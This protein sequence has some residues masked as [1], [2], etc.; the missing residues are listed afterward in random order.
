VT[1]LT[2]DSQG[3]EIAYYVTLSTPE[4]DELPPDQGNA[5]APGES[6]VVMW[7]GLVDEW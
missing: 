3:G 6:G 4:R 7:N 5:T 1:F 2:L